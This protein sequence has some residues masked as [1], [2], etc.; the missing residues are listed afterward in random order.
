MTRSVAQ[1][2]LVYPDCGVNSLLYVD[3]SHDYLARA[4]YFFNTK[5]VVVLDHFRQFRKVDGVNK[6]LYRE[7]CWMEST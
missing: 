1:Y 7:I 3:H 2:R 5:F 6:W 4:R